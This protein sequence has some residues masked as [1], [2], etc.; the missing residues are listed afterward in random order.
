V[1]T[2]RAICTRTRYFSPSDE[3]EDYF[4]RVAKDFGVYDRIRFNTEVT[5]ARYDE[6]AQLWCTQVRRA[7]GSVETLESNVLVSAVGAFTTPKFPDIPGFEK[8]RGKVVHTAAWDQSLD[9]TG[10][11]VAVIGNGASAMQL[12]PAIADDVQSLTIFQRS[13][14][15]AAP[16]AKFKKPIP[17]AVRFLFN[18]IPLYEWWYRLRL[19]WIFDSKV[20]PSLQKDPDWHDPEHSLNAQNDGYR[21][22]FT[23]YILGELGDRQDLAPRVVPEFPPY[24]KRMLLDNGWFRTL[25]RPHVE[26]VDVPITAVQE[27][28]IV[29]NT[30]R[31]FDFDVIIVASGF[32]VT[33]F[34]ST[35]PVHGRGGISIR[36]AWHDDDPQAYL[37]TVTPQ[38]PNM[39]TLYGPNTSLGHG[40]AFIFIVECQVNYILSM[41]EQMIET[42]VTEVECREDV[43]ERYNRTM[44]E[45]HERMIWTHPGAR[46]YYQNSKG[47]VVVNSPWRTVDYWRLTRA[48]NLDDYHVKRGALET[49]SAAS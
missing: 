14:Q 39:F 43:C 34:L 1:S 28:G 45:M 46:S 44:D 4:R 18:E 9:L 12:V 7:D 32:D 17:D 24:G 49:A 42:G 5:D 3:I 6:D 35:L 47:R 23:R 25:T 36:E 19:S 16:F 8:F 37:G 38:F 41:L 31:E 2:P 33:R 40:G 26:L 48:A 10:K 30:G 13:K 22:F 15:W 27:N 11:R 29:V 21:R 20:Y